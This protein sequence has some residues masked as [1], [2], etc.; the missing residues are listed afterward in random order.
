MKRL[1]LLCTLILAACSADPDQSWKSVA[2]EDLIGS[3]RLRFSQAR[4]EAQMLGLDLMG[5]L[6]AEL[7]ATDE[8]G[9]VSLCR[10]AAPRLSREHAAELDGRM[11][12]TSH[13]L[14]NS[15]NQAPPWIAD[16]QATEPR[17]YLGPDGE[18]GVT[19]PIKTKKMCLSC[20]GPETELKPAL[21]EKLAELYP[22]DQATGFAEG[23]LRGQFWVE[24]P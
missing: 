17:V 9:A 18:M 4:R 20:H 13:R 2:V 3:D 14:R 24:L 6:T 22:D 16:L 19:L 5:A 23:D 8:V 10:E 11:G 21:V 7:A 1:I 15:A 12:R